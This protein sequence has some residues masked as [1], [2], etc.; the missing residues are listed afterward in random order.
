MVNKR[1]LEN[2]SEKES[3]KKLAEMADDDIDYSDIPD[4]SNAKGWERLYPN[5]TD[6]TVI[7]DKM[8]FEALIKALQESNEK[9]AVTLKLDRKVIDFFKKHSKKYQTKI[10]EVLLA[11]VNNYENLHNH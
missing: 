2:L 8:M 9:L 5:A 3:L 4:M 7:T 10:N 6:K 1:K 11:F